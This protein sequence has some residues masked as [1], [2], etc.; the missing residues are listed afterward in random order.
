MSPVPAPASEPAR[1]KLKI[2][3]G[4]APGVGKTFQMLKDAHDAVHRDLG[5]V[6]G[7]FETHKRR[8]TLALAEGLEVV[9]RRQI[10]YR[11][12]AFA[13]M[14]T[15]AILR[16]RPQLCLVDEFAHTNVPGAERG[17]RWED[18]LVLLDAG[19]D[20]WTTM[21]VQHIE[22][23]NDAVFEITGIRVRETVPDWVIKQ[24]TDLQLVDVTAEALL[25]RLRRGAVYV[26][27][28]AQKA[29][30]SF[31][32]ESHLR[33]LRELAMR[34]AA[35]EVEM[36]QYDHGSEVAAP[37]AGIAAEP[38]A[39][40]TPA[41]S[42]ER[43]LLFVTADPTTAMLARRARRV[44][45]YLHGDCLALY[46]HREEHFSNL[47]A[48][49]RE[50]IERYLN[51]ARNLRIEARILQGQDIARTLVEFARCNQVTQIFVSRA[52]LHPRSLPVKRNLTRDIIHF[53]P[54][55]Q[56]T[57]VAT[58]RRDGTEE[59]PVSSL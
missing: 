47:P 9:P 30:E 17:K 16:R 45:D 12:R 15:D 7:Y 58:R 39:C 29:V 5:L 19:I 48:V 59:P 38:T 3:L 14:D 33:A 42:K 35:H 22:S 54:D 46:I 53:A 23:L 40:S 27:D 2:Y 41:V 56:I 43:I 11:G 36:R 34:E 28:M 37:G 18:V 49:E 57:V 26:G 10:T 21:N 24:S 1:G 4:Y 32:R 55:L 8:D 44:A 13:E 31:F 6:I 50:E 20:V 52:L 51:F 25:N